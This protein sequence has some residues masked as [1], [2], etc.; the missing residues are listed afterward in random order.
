MNII[1]PGCVMIQG[2]VRLHKMKVIITIGTETTRKVERISS[3][4]VSYIT[5][6]YNVCCDFKTGFCG[7]II[8]STLH[9][10]Y[11]FSFGEIYT[12]ML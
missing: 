10:I 5:L 2:R 12:C 8:L 4:Q 6:V 1:M 7:K 11:I 9:N 3:S